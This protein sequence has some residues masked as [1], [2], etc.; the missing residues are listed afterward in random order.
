M[1]SGCAGPRS[2]SR[3]NCL[4]HRRRRAW[5][6]AI[7]FAPTRRSSEI[8]EVVRAGGNGA[9]D[10]H[11]AARGATARLRS[12]ATSRCLV[13]LPPRPA[14]HVP[15]NSWTMPVRPLLFQQA[16]ALEPNFARATR[17]CRSTHFQGCPAALHDDNVAAR[18]P[19][20]L[21]VR[22]ERPSTTRSIPFAN[23]TMGRP[24]C[25][26]AT[27]KA[28][29]RGS[30]AQTHSTRTSPRRATPGHG[31]SP[32]LERPPRA[33]STPMRRGAQP[34]GS[35]CLRHAG[36]AL[37][38]HMGRDEPAEAA[39]WAERAANSPGAHVLIELIAVAAH[40]MD[41]NDAR[42]S[43]MG[44]FRAPA[45]ARHQQ[46]GVPARLSLPRP[47]GTGPHWCDPEEIRLLSG[48][49][50]RRRAVAH[51]RDEPERPALAN[52][53]HAAR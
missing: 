10:P 28:A 43:F 11:T 53:S 37:F 14:P 51:K 33:L 21:P 18:H 38:S 6:G 3:S 22:G 27:S 25:C 47:T 17:A 45:R 23:F 7:A 8:R 39:V 9:R 46:R 15:F 26:A 13:G 19:T 24:S 31:A 30:I 44:R 36:G 50:L 16:V 40:G 2:P 1:R 41:G 34:A 35:A 12:P 42:A 4:R 52:P 32:L 49:G 5:C 20:H 29:C 48:E